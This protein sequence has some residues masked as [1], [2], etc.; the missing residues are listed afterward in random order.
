MHNR[1]S[2][3]R[4]GRPAGAGRTDAGRLVLAGAVV[5]LGMAC[6]LPAAAETLKVWDNY[7]LEAQS[8]VVNGLNKQFE[9]AHPGVTIERTART[10]DDLGMTLRLAVSAGDGPVVTQVNQGAG[11]MGTM[12][13]ETLLI[14]LDAYGAKFGWDKRQSESV[15]ARNRW[16][17]TGQFGT[18]TDYGISGLGEMVGVY[19]NKKVLEDAGIKTPIASFEDFE[20]ALAT[21]KEKGIVPIMI[22]TLKRHMALHLFAAISQAHITA[23]KRAAFDDLVYGRGGSW[24]TAENLTAATKLQDWVNK[25]YLYPGFEGISGDDAIPLFIGNQAGFL[26][27]GTWYLGDMEQNPDI[28][29][30]SMPGP[31]GDKAALVIGGT[32]LA[33]A[34]TSVAKDEATRDLAAE[35]I[36]FM[37]SDTAAAA[38]ASHAFLPA[39]PLDHPDEVK[40]GPLLAEVIAVWQNTNA[41]DAL[42][43][44][45]DWASPTMIKTMSEGLQILLANGETPEA[46]VDALDAD[47]AAYMATKKSQ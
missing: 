12:A 13:H 45:P 39:K 23:A 21:L 17:D 44:Y 8:D 36:D 19:Y 27:S 33:W 24:K 3:R 5:G 11:D 37:T 35:Y 42:G 28:H 26:V 4:F 7:T 41:N 25:G 47:Y 15:I 6:A 40:V 43:H 1:I 10:F 22:G 18:G 32:D 9:A 31:G 14:P 46:F 2:Q 20:A 29:F 16:S 38:W 30:Q 34:I